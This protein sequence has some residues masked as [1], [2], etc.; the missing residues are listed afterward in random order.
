MRAHMRWAATRGANTAMPR[1][2]AF[3]RTAGAGL[4]ATAEH[5]RPV[6]QAAARGAPG[7]FGGQFGLEL[8]DR[9]PDLR[10]L[11]L[12]AAADVVLDAETR[13]QDAGLSLQIAVQ[14][15]LGARHGH[16]SYSPPC[17]R[18]WK[19]AD[20]F[21]SGQAPGAARLRPRLAVEVALDRRSVRVVHEGGH[22]VDDRPAPHAPD[23]QIDLVSGGLGQQPVQSARGDRVAD[24]V[25][26]GVEHDVV[27]AVGQ[28][29]LNARLVLRRP[30]GAVVEAD[31]LLRP[32]GEH[33]RGALAKERHRQRVVF[34]DDHALVLVGGPAQGPAMVPPRAPALLV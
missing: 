25:D 4:S 17:P 10:E 7:G 2:S 1:S 3:M 32:P 34:H 8:G 30:A 23:T 16:P 31:Q 21:Y 14:T 22:G 18:S 9:L 11:G 20:F 28:Q 13:S 27:V 5:R 15:R 19:T 26:Q 33:G 29:P 6:A 24:P 12:L